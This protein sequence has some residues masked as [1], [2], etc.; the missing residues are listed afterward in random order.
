MPVAIK[1]AMT[2]MRLNAWHLLFDSLIFITKR[3]PPLTEIGG[4]W[5][6]FPQLHLH[7]DFTAATGKTGSG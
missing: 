7:Y 6:A 1:I 2:A 3:C 4:E 5:R